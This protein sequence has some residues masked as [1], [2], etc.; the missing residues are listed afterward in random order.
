MFIK[1]QNGFGKLMSHFNKKGL[2][3]FLFISE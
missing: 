2:S 3:I 1:M